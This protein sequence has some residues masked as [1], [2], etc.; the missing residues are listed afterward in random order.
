MILLFISV[1][2]VIGVLLFVDTGL[3]VTSV[4]VIFSSVL[5]EGW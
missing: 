2:A 3:Y 5:P 4:L 1:F